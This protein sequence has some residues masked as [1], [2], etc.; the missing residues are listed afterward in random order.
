MNE[1]STILANEDKIAMGVKNEHDIQDDL[2]RNQYKKIKDNSVHNP[3]LKEVL[4]GLTIHYDKKEK[5]K[6]QQYDALEKLMD[7]IDNVNDNGELSP[8]LQNECKN[9]KH[10]LIREMQKIRNDI[11]RIID[12]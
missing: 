8:T 6:E 4:G 5:E 3:N 7:Y 12:K 10:L 2:L 11:N 9:D 1:L